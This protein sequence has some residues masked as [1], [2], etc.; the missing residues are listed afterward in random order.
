[1]NRA[2]TLKNFLDHKICFDPKAKISLYKAAIILTLVILTTFITLWF[3]KDVLFPGQISYYDYRIKE[4]Q[5]HLDIYPE[6]RIAVLEL[7]MNYYLKGEEKKGIRLVEKVLA[8]YPHDAK[9]LLNLGLMLSDRGQYQESIKALEKLT[10]VKPGFEVAKVSFYLGRS[11]YETGNYRDSLRNLEQA[12]LR[13]PGYPV[14]YYYLG[15]AYEKTGDHTKAIKTLQK[16]IYLS[17][18][19]PEAEKALRRLASQ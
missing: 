6:D 15:L 7:A 4:L 2:K 17:G 10:Q 11:Y 12:V 9:A 8:K 13:D 14:A 16:G 18:S 19:Y 5:Q 3:L 1:M